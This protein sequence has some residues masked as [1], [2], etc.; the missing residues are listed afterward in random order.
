MYFGSIV[1]RS[2]KGNVF[3]MIFGKTLQDIPNEANTS[4]RNPDGTVTSWQL[5]KKQ[6]VKNLKRLKNRWASPP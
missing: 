6:L 5:D 1:F 2:L 4:F 3:S